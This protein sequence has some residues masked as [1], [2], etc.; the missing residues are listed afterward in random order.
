LPVSVLFDIL[1]VGCP[2]VAGVAGIAIPPGAL[3]VLKVLSI[4]AIILKFLALPG[5]AAL[6]LAGRG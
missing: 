2:V 1:G 5:L 6:A 3:R 4:E